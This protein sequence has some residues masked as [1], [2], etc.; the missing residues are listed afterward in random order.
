MNNSRK[1][2]QITIDLVHPDQTLG[3]VRSNQTIV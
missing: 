1:K 2:I 3:V